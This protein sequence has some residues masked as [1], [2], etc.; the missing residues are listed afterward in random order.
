ML[1]VEN[2][3]QASTGVENFMNL[4]KLWFNNPSLNFL[5]YL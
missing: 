1:M 4:F 3:N 2:K 5:N